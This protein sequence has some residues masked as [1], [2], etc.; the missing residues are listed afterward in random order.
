MV[1][2]RLDTKYTN[3]IKKHS[4]SVQHFSKMRQLN[5]LMTNVQWFRKNIRDVTVHL[6]PY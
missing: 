3:P 6:Q 4:D 2:F 1:D 5:S